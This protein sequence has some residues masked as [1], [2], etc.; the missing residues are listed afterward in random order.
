MALLRIE[1]FNLF[2]TPNANLKFS[3]DHTA[4]TLNSASRSGQ[5]G[6]NC[7]RLT[8]NSGTG[9]M[10]GCDI[11]T[12]SV[13]LATNHINTTAIVGV[14]FKVSALPTSTNKMILL[15]L[16]DGSFGS[17]GAAIYLDSSG[18]LHFLKS[19]ATTVTESGYTGPTIATATWYYLEF[20]CKYTASA[21]SGD[22]SMHVNGSAANSNTQ[23]GISTE[24]GG[25]GYTFVTLGDNNG[26]ATGVNSA[27]ID[28]DDL[29]I[30]DSS[31]SANNDF[32]GDCTVEY[33]LPTGAG[34]ST[35]WTLGAGSTNHGSVADTPAQDGD[36]TYVDTAGTGNRDS[37]TIGSLAH[38]PNSVFGVQVTAYARRDA[39]ET[40]RTMSIS[41]R[42]S[43]TYEDSST[44]PV[45]TA[46]Y[47]P[48][49]AVFPLDA[50]GSAWTGS[51]VNSAE[52]GIKL[53][54]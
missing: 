4:G 44:T 53:V 15:S 23:T 9:V 40:T 38:T 12:S 28:Y 1:G 6:S 7:W 11:S 34:A 54:A 42:T 19:G 26:H 22:M 51:T 45:L 43:S 25:T 18:T 29:Y 37:Y 32:L 50:G 33:L 5:S 31:G 35:Q 13:N 39:G 30:C 49:M 2:A 41:M 46:T 16:V 8:T 10:P 36:T 17:P 24:N 20:K 47:A 14:A 27:T 21:A 48:Y 52:V 3:G